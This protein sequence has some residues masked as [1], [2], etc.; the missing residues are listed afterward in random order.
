MAEVAAI[1][2]KDAATPLVLRLAPGDYES[3][4]GLVIDRRHADRKRGWGALKI[5]AADPENRPRL[6]GGIPVRGWKLTPFNGRGDVW[7]ADVSSLCLPE[8]TRL[9]LFNGKRMEAAR[10][11]NVDPARPYTSGFAFA[12]G[13]TEGPNA[14]SQKPVGMYTDEIPMRVED[15]RGWSNP[16]EGWVLVFPRHN[17]WNRV[18]SIT[19]VTKDGVIKLSEK[20]EKVDSRLFIWDR[21]CIQGVKEELDAPGEWYFD[22][23]GGR[24]YFIPPDGADPNS[25]VA[26]VALVPQIV[27]VEDCA[28]VVLESLE[29]AGG[30]AG[31]T[32]RRSENVAVRGCSIHDVGFHTG[33]GV[34]AEG[35]RIAICDN[36]IWNVGSHGIDIGG[37]GGNSYADRAGSTVENNYIHHVGQVNSHGIGVTMYGQGIS[38]LHNY[39]HDT[40]RCGI[41][42]YGRFCD[43]AYNRIRHTNTINDDT[44]AIYGCGWT[45][46]QGTT[47][48]YNWI[49]DSIGFQRQRDGSYRHFK[50][51]CGI[52]PDEGCGGLAVYGNLVE[53]CHHVAM[54]L[55]NGRWITIS[56][57]VFISNGAFPVG[58]ETAQL[59]LQTWN[60]ATNGYFVKTRR[61][62][63]SREY[64]K[65]VDAD[66]RWLSEPSLAQAPDRDDVCFNENGTT[67]MG[68]NFRNNIVYYPDQGQGMMLRS[69]DLQLDKNPFDGNVYWP[70]QSTNVLQRS[71]HKGGWKGWLAAGQDTHSIIADPFFRDLP[72]HDY[73]LKPESPAWKLGF[74]ELPYAEMGLKATRL[75]KSM[76]GEAEGVREHPEWLESPAAVP[77]S[78]RK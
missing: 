55:H 77:K 13:K 41:F 29:V 4:N 31:I 32:I 7:S 59:S 54:H 6:L 37:D 11:P 67:M 69:W 47:V 44:G 8:R 51:A 30:N 1:R 39:I 60:S 38:I 63:I 40:P 36:D 18:Y 15:R 52:Y 35:H 5:V 74:K 9:F 73:H 42:G 33:S 19:N 21:W 20:H 17:W 23:K 22:R 3:R 65:L 71:G 50:G 57:N 26:T 72:N 28:N 56:N 12:D 58:R 75:R 78:E 68:V 46:G 24:I 45:C 70:G 10:W 2:T 64:H 48:R 34:S 14:Y 76:P 16:S 49:S 66:P 61:K 27:K 43:I 53:H 25:G 62:A